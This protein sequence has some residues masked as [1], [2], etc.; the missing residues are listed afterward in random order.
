LTL[1]DEPGSGGPKQIQLS[2]D[3]KVLAVYYRNSHIAVWDLSR[4][5]ELRRIEVGVK[6]M[7]A[8]SLSR[9][10]KFLLTSQE[11]AL[12]TWRIADGKKVAQLRHRPHSGIIA[13]AFSPQDNGLVSS[14]TECTLL[15]WRQATWQGKE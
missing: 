13:V 11:G 8:W 7:S 2:D 10:G 14:C 1:P 4:Q 5:T 9:D 6:G 12:H 3:G 15:R